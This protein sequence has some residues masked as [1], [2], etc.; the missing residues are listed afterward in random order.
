MFLDHHPINVLSTHLDAYLTLAS[1]L[2]P[3]SDVAVGVV[4]LLRNLC[5]ATREVQ[6]Q[7]ATDSALAAPIVALLDRLSTAPDLVPVTMRR[8]A[9]QLLSNA[10]AD[11][12]AAQ[13]AWWAR[14]M[15]PV[16][17]APTGRAA[18]L[19]AATVGDD[20]SLA[21]IICWLHNATLFASGRRAALGQTPSTCL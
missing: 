10:C 19:V 11:H 20:T 15:T 16:E 8:A 5:V 6:A 13:G 4:R 14:L 3:A 12:S 17:A 9:L 2:P 18:L 1:P 7:L 21:A